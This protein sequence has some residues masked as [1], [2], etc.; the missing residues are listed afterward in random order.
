MNVNPSVHESDLPRLATADCVD[1]YWREI[2]GDAKFVERQVICKFIMCSF[3]VRLV[4]MP[5]RTS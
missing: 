3:A 5:Q 2:A 1:K 4:M